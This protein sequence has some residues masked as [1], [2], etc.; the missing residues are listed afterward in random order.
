VKTYQLFINGQY[1]D[2]AKGEW[3]E[4]IDPYRGKPWAKIP[5]GSAADAVPGRK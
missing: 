2:P 5:R 4:S 1:L 3:F